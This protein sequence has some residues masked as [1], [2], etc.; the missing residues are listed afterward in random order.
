MQEKNMSSH[1]CNPK[2]SSEAG[3]RDGHIPNSESLGIFPVK[4]VFLLVQA[5]EGFVGHQICLQ[6]IAQVCSVSWVIQSSREAGWPC[7]L[8]E[9]YWTWLCLVLLLQRR[10]KLRANHTNNYWD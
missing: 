5:P 2:L 4:E 10:S 3:G 8:G 6:C 9:E 1:S 7:V